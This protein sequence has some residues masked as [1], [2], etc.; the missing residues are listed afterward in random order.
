VSIFIGIGIP[1]PVLDEDMARRVSVKN[2]QITTLVCD[3][4]KPDHPVIGKVNY[5]EL[6]SGK[7]ALN[8]KSIR[9]ASL[10]SVAKARIIADKL[11]TAII[12]KDF[13]LSTPVQMFPENTSLNKLERRSE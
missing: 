8:G 13:Y 7:I 4:S 1:I 11:K 12:G 9:A 6:F 5:A 10:S 3:Y 2:E